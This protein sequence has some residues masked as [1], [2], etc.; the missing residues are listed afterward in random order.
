MLHFLF[1]VAFFL[2]TFQSALGNSGAI[3][4]N[5]A[6]FFAAVATILARLGFPPEA[7]PLS[8]EQKSIIVGFGLLAISIPSSM[9]IGSVFAGVTLS[10]RDFFELHRPIFYLAIFLSGVLSARRYKFESSILKILYFVFWIAIIIGLLQVFWQDRSVFGVYTKVANIAK[11]RMAAPFINPYDFAFFLSFYC[12]L[13]VS[14]FGLV[15]ER[16]WTACAI[17]IVALLAMLFTQSRSVFIGTIFAVLF[18]VP[19]LALYLGASQS[20]SVKGYVVRFGVA[21]LVMLFFLVLGFAALANMFPYLV[22]SILN[23]VSEG[24]VGTSASIRV[25]Q[26]SFSLEKAA[27][28]PLVLFFGNGPAKDEMPIVESLYTYLFY[29]YGIFGLIVYLLAFIALP[30]LIAVRG[31]RSSISNELEKALFLGFSAWC[32]SMGVMFLGNNFTEQTR[33]YFFYF[34]LVGYVSELSISRRRSSVSG[35]GVIAT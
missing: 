22:N 1:V 33:L 2:P 6:I 24:K 5:L 25:L 13:F 4:V 19:V 9:L 21:A 31:F 29:R 14:F 28:N 11:S 10:T 3:L 26:L 32:I 16:R 15:R 30:V 17:T 7:F 23:F 12:C 35:R 20:F 34:F 18:V 27:N 8:R